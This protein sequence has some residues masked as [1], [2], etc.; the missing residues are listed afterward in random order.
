[1]SEK[2]PE[3]PLRKAR[4][5]YEEANKEERKKATE[6]FNTRLP[7][8]DYEE[9]CD[10]LEKH[11]IRKIDLIYAGYELLQERFDPNSKWNKP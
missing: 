10:F 6:Q 4:R 1:M 8:K 9:I 11:H 7:R 3:T 5:K 2:K